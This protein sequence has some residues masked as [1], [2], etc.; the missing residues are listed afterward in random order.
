MVDLEKA[1]IARLETHGE[2][3]EILIDPEVA[4]KF[5][6]GEDVDLVENMVIDTVFKDARKGDKASEEKMKEIF[7]TTDVTPIAKEIVEKGQVQLTTEQRKEMQENKK[8]QVVAEIA[9]NAVNPQTGAPHPPQRIENAMEEAKVHIDPFKPLEILVNEVMGALRPLMPIRFEK[10]RI[11]VRLSGDD[12]GKC[13]GDMKGYGSI[14]KEEWQKDG[15]WIGVVEIPAGLQTEFFEKLN[16][17]TKG[18]VE[19]KI[20][21]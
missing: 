10:V 17:R 21:K 20:L 8:K 11:A 9:R 14:Q 6:K 15:S 16:S 13:Y 3:F 2:N 1:I 19:T 12:Y 4:Q 5:K 18:S 7:G